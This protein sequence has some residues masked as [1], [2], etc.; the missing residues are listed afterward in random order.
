MILITIHR[1]MALPISYLCFKFVSNN[2]YSSPTFTTFDNCQND[3]SGKII[4]TVT[5]A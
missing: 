1:Y 3:H 2:N 4:Y 5:V